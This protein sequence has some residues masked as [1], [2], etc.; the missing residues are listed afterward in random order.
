METVMILLVIAVLAGIGYLI[1]QLNAKGKEN[2]N[3]QENLKQIELQV[4]NAVLQNLTTLNQSV[5]KNFEAGREELKSIQSQSLKDTQ[6]LFSKSF[7]L[8]ENR[9]DQMG[10]GLGE[11]SKANEFLHMLFNPS[12]RGKVGEVQ[13]A[14]L[15][16]D[17]LAPTQYEK[18]FQP[19]PQQ[20]LRV[21]F[22][23]KMPTDL[24]QS[25]YLPID[26][27]F[28]KEEYERLLKAETKEEVD[29]SQKLLRSKLKDFARD[30]SRYINVPRTTE[31]AV[32]YLPDGIFDWAITQSDLITQL[33]NEHK[34]VVAG[35]STLWMMISFV[36]YFFRLMAIN[37][38]SKEVWSLL[39]KF[40]KQMG[41]TLDVI[42]KA[43]GHNDQVQKNLES[44]KTT[45][46]NVMMRELK[47]V[48]EDVERRDSASEAA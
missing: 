19:D 37:D 23:V 22:A 4:Q 48:E 38:K 20:G 41:I 42:D 9:M 28:P 44:L 30:V 6:F 46:Y 8:I 5:N 3:L 31:M 26:S 47:D 17:I 45:R 10:K 25:M 7:G 24:G 16:A 13:L 43:I 34:V 18:N 33:R 15:L 39:G 2:I 36:S 1:Y 29:R 12:A 35:P 14:G 40:K 21:E 11:I 32:M 27:K